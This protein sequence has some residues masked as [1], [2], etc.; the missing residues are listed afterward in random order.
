MSRWSSSVCRSAL[1]RSACRP[2]T[3]MRPVMSE[4]MPEKRSPTGFCSG[5]PASP[6]VGLMSSAVRRPE[7]VAETTKRAFGAPKALRKSA[8]RACCM[9]CSSPF[10]STLCHSQLRPPGWRGVETARSTTRLTSASSAALKRSGSSR[11]LLGSAR[12][13][14]IEDAPVDAARH[15]HGLA[16]HRTQRGREARGLDRVDEGTLGGGI[17]ARGR[18]KPRRTAGLQR[19][20]AHVGG[21]ERTG[22]LPDCL[23]EGL[24][25]RHLDH[26]VGAYLG[27]EA[28][29]CALA[30]PQ[31]AIAFAADDDAELG[32]RGQLLERRAIEKDGVLGDIERQFGVGLGIG[33][34]HAGDALHLLRRAGRERLARPI[35][36]APVA[37]LGGLGRERGPLRHGRQRLDMSCGIV[38]RTEPEPAR[39][40]PGGLGRAH[41]LAQP[42]G[43]RRGRGE[44][45][46]DIKRGGQADGDPAGREM[47]GHAAHPIAPFWRRSAAIYG[48]V[49][50]IP[51]PAPG[52][53]AGCGISP[54]RPARLRPVVA[55]QR[56]R[57]RSWPDPGRSLRAATPR[58]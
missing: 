45:Q 30:L 56:C 27:I 55:R 35:D 4:T 31:D 18:G 2:A 50:V 48:I 41:H 34:Q 39:A 53:E 47:L 22:E 13:L 17:D 1:R 6:V 23:L 14:H 21:F 40:R 10:T 54:A 42:I 25:A 11:L 28:L 26:E 7:G 36:E 46:R 3:T 20:D 33:Q 9:A 52:S 29:G 49:D 58:A 19:E 38:E 15:Q 16:A 57:A 44:R 12:R 51:V 24:A 8:S 5:P 37:L 43:L 32:A